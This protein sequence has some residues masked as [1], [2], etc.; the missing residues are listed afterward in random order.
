M[1]NN[2][3]G[4]TTLETLIA[5]VIVS[6]AC[7]LI[8][9]SATLI[10]SSGRKTSAAVR[11]ISSVT[12]ADRLMRD[13]VGGV[14]IPYWERHAAISENA[15]SFTIPWY[16]GKRGGELSLT[17]TEEGLEITVPGAE[18][19][20]KYVVLRQMKNITL[21]LIASSGGQ[22]SGVTVSW[23]SLSHQYQSTLPFGSFFRE[24]DK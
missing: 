13:L 2:D 17:V 12:V 21:G 7:T 9:A 6:L 3:G 10:L 11:T 15:G 19:P 14:R 1:K 22:P 23:D 4:T 16:R 24:A 5:V 8:F 18:A 20:A